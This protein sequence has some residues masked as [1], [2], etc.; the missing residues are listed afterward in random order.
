MEDGRCNAT[1]SSVINLKF[2]VWKALIKASDI[3]EFES[4]TL[5]KK[6][7]FSFPLVESVV[8]VLV[9]KTLAVKIR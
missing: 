1:F 2:K 3:R 9:N 6:F 7:Q 4:L 5:D 8:L